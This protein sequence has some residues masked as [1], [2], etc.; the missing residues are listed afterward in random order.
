M[1]WARSSPRVANPKTLRLPRKV[2]RAPSANHTAVAWEKWE[3]PLGK[4]SLMTSFGDVS[5]TGALYDKAF[6]ELARQGPVSLE[7]VREDCVRGANNDMGTQDDDTGESRTS[8]PSGASRPFPRRHRI[9]APR[10]DRTNHPRLSCRVAMPSLPFGIY[11][12]RQ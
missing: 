4:P 5:L 3:L 8:A 12:K 2:V 9:L 1:P 11:D 6:C 7:K 10:S